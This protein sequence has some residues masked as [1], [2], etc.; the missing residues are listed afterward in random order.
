M[1]ITFFQVLLSVICVQTALLVSQ[2]PVSISTH[3][4]FPQINNSSVCIYI[5][6][7]TGEY[8]N[9][10]QNIQATRR[11][12]KSLSRLILCYREDFANPVHQNELV[13]RERA[14]R[15]GESTAW[16]P[17]GY[18]SPKTDPVL[19]RLLEL[20]VGRHEMHETILE[21]VIRVGCYNFPGPI[22]SVTLD[23]ITPS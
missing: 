5:W 6:L 18:I 15:L 4:L 3:S 16:F 2:Q 9:W 10:C 14:D 20:V 7:E 8:P 13:F 17:S 21:H 23:K 12:S 19:C 22:L 11:L 1:V